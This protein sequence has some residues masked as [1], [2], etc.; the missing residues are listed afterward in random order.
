MPKEM[1]RS[2]TILLLV[3]IGIST[4]L[5]QHK[6]DR[7]SLDAAIRTLNEQ[8]KVPL[9]V[10]TYFPFSPVSS[11]KERRKPLYAS[12]LADSDS[13]EL[14][15]CFS[16]DSCHGAYFYAEISAEKVTSQTENPHFDKKLSLAKGI[17]GYFAKSSCGAS[18]APE[19]ITWDEGG[20]RYTV[21]LEVNGKVDTIARFVNSAINN[22]RL[23]AVNAPMPATE[24]FESVEAFLKATLKSGDSKE[25]DAKGDLNGDGLA[26]WAGLIQR[27]KEPPFRENDL[28][29]NQTVQLYVLLRRPQGNFVIAERSKE[30]GSFGV[31]NLYFEDLSIERLSLYLQLNGGARYN[32]ISQ[33]RL[34]KGEWRLV[35]WQENEITSGPSDEV[36]KR[37]RKNRNLLTGSV[38]ESRQ[39]GDRTR[40]VKRYK[41]RFPRILLRDFDLY[42]S[43][44][45]Q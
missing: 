5:G 29:T 2:S 13:F 42:G 19:S 12:V 43:D 8:T 17:T 41:K 21:F 3:L 7:R 15:F 4:V 10:P 11:A 27:K 37:F 36:F 25:L 30:S 23:T 38:I 22:D 34:Y 45:I 18:C 1:M 24:K 20:Y 6:V 16:P 39:T 40:V 26:D 35:G 14:N 9:K 33:F 31:G 44:K 32:S 28:E